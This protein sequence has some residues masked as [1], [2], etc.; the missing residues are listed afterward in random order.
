MNLRTA[1]LSGVL[2]LGTVVL[3][4]ETVKDRE[5]AVRQDRAALEHDARWIYNDFE[6]GFAEAARTGKPLLVAL[7]CVPCLACLGMDAA[8]LSDEALAPLL[9]RFVCVRVINANALDLVRFQ[10]DFDLSFSAMFFNGDGTVYGRFGSWTHQRNA[11]DSDLSGFRAALEAVEELHR[12]Y[13][14]NR[15]ALAGKQGGPLPFRTPVEIPGLA[16]KYGRELDWQGRVVPSCVHCHQIGDALRAVEREAGRALAM[17]LIYPMPPPET[18]GFSLSP[19]HAAQVSAVT[20]D[21]AAARAGLRPGDQLVSLAGQPLISV[22]DVAWALHRAPDAAVLSADIRRGGAGQT[23]RLELAAG[24]R[25]K[26]DISRRVGTWA[27]RAMA[28][29]GLVLDEAGDERRRELGLSPDTMALV[30]SHVGQYG[31]HAA[32]Q[33]AGFVAEDVVIAADGLSARM[34]EGE[35]IG[36]LLRSRRAGDTIRVTVRRGAETLDL[37]LPMQ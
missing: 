19:S 30:V 12:N 3:R 17:E 8:I 14:A 35:L 25:A 22:A 4:A 2:L 13:P 16:G 10:F 15:A 36:R 29:G 5:G 20:A 18:V 21:S 6:R 7:R 32:G 28:L 33:R 1:W 31:I 27:M 34:S 11:Q 37:A 23:L 9:D 26:A 24:W